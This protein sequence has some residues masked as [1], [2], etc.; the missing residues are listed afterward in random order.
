MTTLTI[1]RGLP[2]SGKST[3]ARDSLLS[4]KHTVIVE[5]DILRELHPRGEAEELFAYENKITK[6][7]HR[8]IKH[9]LGCGINVISSDTN[10]RDKYVRP[11]LK[12]AH[13]AEADVEWVDFRACWL[14]D[15]VRYNALRKNPVPEDYIRTC[16]AKYIRGRD[17][18]VQPA[19]DPSTDKTAEV[20][21]YVQPASTNPLQAVI[22]DIDNTLA[23]MGD[24][25]PY[26]GSL[27]HLD[28]PNKEVRKALRLY[29]RNGTRVLIVSGRSEEY[30][31]VTE[32]WLLTHG[33]PY[34]KLY[35]RPEGDSREDSIIKNELFDKHIRD[36]GYY[37]AGVYD[38][39]HRVLRMWLALGLTTFHINGPD[40]GNF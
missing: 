39:R 33:I 37:I 13:E 32:T 36:E 21:P 22:F 38:D 23:I 11:L 19:Y 29:Y 12:L 24:R 7:Q 30:R 14:E 34:D 1:Y 8:L 6:H 25:S 4:R 26:D 31:K 5:R 17:L 35:M 40:A 10:L 28:T 2:G 16:H 20:V 15:V 18:S 9:L 3:D 27:V